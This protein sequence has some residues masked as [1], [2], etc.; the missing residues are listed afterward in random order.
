MLMEERSVSVLKLHYFVTV[1]SLTFVTDDFENRKHYK[2]T[3]QELISLK[4]RWVDREET[5]TR[6]CSWPLFALLFNE[7]FLAILFAFA[8]SGLLYLYSLQVRTFA[9]WNN[10]G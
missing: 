1:N 7:Q 3:G 4:Y 5:L 6:G 10:F 2:I 8:R 9:N